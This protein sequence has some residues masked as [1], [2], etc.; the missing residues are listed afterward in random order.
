[1]KCVGL[2]FNTSRIKTVDGI[3]ENN[4]Y[5]HFVNAC[6]I[7]HISDRSHSRLKNHHDAQVLEAQFSHGSGTGRSLN[8]LTYT[9]LQT[10]K[11][12]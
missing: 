6:F 4:R 5:R 8:D 2:F 12:E 7:L 3:P 9:Y 1:M 10:L 11:N